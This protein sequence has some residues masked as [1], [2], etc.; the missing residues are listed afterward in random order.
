MATGQPLLSAVT[1]VPQQ[2]IG[3]AQRP[4][5]KTDLFTDPGQTAICIQAQTANVLT[6]CLRFRT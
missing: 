3:M 4:P 2:Y 6:R 5:P 1:D